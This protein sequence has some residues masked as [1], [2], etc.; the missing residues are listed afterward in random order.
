MAVMQASAAIR[1]DSVWEIDRAV[2]HGEVSTRHWFWG[3]RAGA[4]ELLDGRVA[5]RRNEWLGLNLVM[6]SA[7]HHDASVTIEFDATGFS[8]DDH[9]SFIVSGVLRI[10]GGDH[11][12]E[13]RLRDLGTSAVTHLPERRF[14]TIAGRVDM[15]SAGHPI[16]RRPF[17]GRYL[18]IFAHTEWVTR[19]DTT[20]A[21]W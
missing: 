15:P 3:R 12:V 17:T 5:M 19:T 21:S 20:S 7:A 6:R 1:S 14:A 4:L 13:W 11:D 8:R 16:W 18:T 2:S 10:D 9:G